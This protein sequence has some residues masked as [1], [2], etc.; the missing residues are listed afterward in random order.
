VCTRP[1]RVVNAVFDA[2]HAEVHRGSQDMGAAR[3]RTG[4][5][6]PVD[7]MGLASYASSARHFVHASGCGWSE[8]T[9]RPAPGWPLLGTSCESPANRPRA[10]GIRR[11]HIS[12]KSPHKPWISTD[13]SVS[14]R[15]TEPRVP[16]QCRERGD[17]DVAVALPWRAAF[18]RSRCVAVC[19]ALRCEHS[20]LRCPT[21]RGRVSR[22]VHGLAGSSSRPRRKVAPG[23][24]GRPGAP[25]DANLQAPGV[26]AACV[27]VSLRS[28]ALSRS[29]SSSWS[30]RMMMRQAASRAVP[31]STSS[32]ARVAMRSW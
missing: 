32:R 7:L 24:R 3:H 9:S 15:R 6:T 13:C 2:F 19:P 16:G 1:R 27:Q 23:G 4:H 20:A 29:A 17:I 14:G 31:A 21:R 18:P 11:G 30:S 28:S 5:R 25:G 22:E 10:T 8:R 26:R 12:H